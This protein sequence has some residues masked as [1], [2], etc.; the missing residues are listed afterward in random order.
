MI[1]FEEPFSTLQQTDSNNLNKYH[2]RLQNNFLELTIQV[3]LQKV[4]NSISQWK[5]FR[6]LSIYEFE[7]II[8]LA[9]YIGSNIFSSVT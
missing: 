5:L 6:V 3:G 1:S 7:K 2:I 4:F 8:P 9:E